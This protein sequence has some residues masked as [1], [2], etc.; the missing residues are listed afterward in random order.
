MDF[1]TFQLDIH[2]QNDYKCHQKEKEDPYQTN[3]IDGRI[4]QEVWPEN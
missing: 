4:P 1:F 2:K 3:R